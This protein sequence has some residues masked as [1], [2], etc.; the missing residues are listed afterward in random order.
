MSTYTDIRSEIEALSEKR[1]ALWQRLSETGDKT[2]RTEIKA[3]EAEIEALW[4]QSRQERARIR[5]GDRKAIIARARAEERL[6][7]AA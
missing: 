1:T 4:E 7:R 2:I 6:E 5:F 3:V